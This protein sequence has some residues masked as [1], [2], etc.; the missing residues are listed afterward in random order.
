MMLAMCLATV[1]GLM[2]S[3]APMPLLLRPSAT[4]LA[5]CSSLGVSALGGEG[6][7][8]M[9]IAGNAAPADSAAV[10][11]AAVGSSATAIAAA[12]DSSRPRAHSSATAASPSWRA[13]A[14]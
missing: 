11:G 4:S 10:T 7:G 3:S 14:R 1:A 5:I 2:T 13:G 12:G 8:A 6:A 9:A